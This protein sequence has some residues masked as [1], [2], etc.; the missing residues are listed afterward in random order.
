MA[1]PLAYILATLEEVFFFAW[2][3]FSKLQPDIKSKSNFTHK[4]EPKLNIVRLLLLFH[5]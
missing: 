4:V 2:L 1:A 3:T 5:V